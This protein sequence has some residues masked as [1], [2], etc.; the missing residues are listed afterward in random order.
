MNQAD[1]EAL[2]HRWTRDALEAAEL[3]RVVGGPVSEEQRDS[4]ITALDVGLEDTQH[5]LMACKYARI[6]P[7]VDDLLREYHLPPVDHSSDSFK[8]LCR[9]LLKARLTFI[10]TELDRWDGNYTAPTNGNGSGGQHTGKSD[11]ASVP[12]ESFLML[13]A[14]IP[15][16]LAHYAHRAP[17]TIEG[18][19]STLRRFLELIGDKPVHRITKKECVVYR[20]TL[21]KVP[22]HIHKRFPGKSVKDV[23][24]MMADGT[25]KASIPLLTRNTANQELMHVNHFMEWLINEGKRP[26]GNPVAGIAFEGIEKKA[27]EEYTDSDITTI[28]TSEDFTRQLGESEYARYFLPLILLYSGC[29]REEAAYLALADVK[30]GGGGIWYFDIA[31]DPTRGRRLKN[32]ASRRKVPIH[33]HLI[34]LG[35][36]NYVDFMKNR[37]ESLLFPKPPDKARG[38]LTLGDT[39]SKYW[40]RVVRGLGLQGKTLH[41]FRPTL[42]TR[43]HAAGV[44]GETRR[45]LLGHSGKDV[46]ETVYLRLTLPVLSGA[47]ER[48]D[49]RALLKGL[50]VFTKLK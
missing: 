28:F 30:Q 13:S 19:R 37:G 22:T 41:G 38:R 39:V 14:A 11:D 18:K 4:H 15:A 32:K 35:L 33:S 45:A 42:T 20:D 23:L 7:D 44:D 49:Y 31:P 3:D 48:V 34:E 1:I 27:R 12:V 29:R 26:P 24:A 10:R 36:L 50:P 46:H 21:L 9:E 8:R 43:L 16:Y 25:V 6:A 5:D 47:L 40:A 17:G 2:I